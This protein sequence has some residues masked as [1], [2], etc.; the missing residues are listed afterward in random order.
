MIDYSLD[1][2]GIATLSWNMP[3]RSQ[4]VLNEESCAVLCELVERVVGD[5]A[6]KG[7]LMTSAKPDFIAGGDLEWLLSAKT[8]KRY[9]NAWCASTARCA[10]WRLAASRS[11]WRC[12]A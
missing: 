6:V 3:G 1:S 10:S 7:V 5:S 12:R 9:S 11:P 2:H 4:N 8:A